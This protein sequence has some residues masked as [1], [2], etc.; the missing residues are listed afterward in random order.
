MAINYDIQRRVVIEFAKSG[1]YKV[2]SWKT[3]VHPMACARICNA[4]AKY[5]ESFFS[6]YPTPLKT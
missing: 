3:G 6:N 4:Y 2:T 5:G 1:S